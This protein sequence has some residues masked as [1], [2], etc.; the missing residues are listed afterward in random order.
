MK[1]ALLVSLLLTVHALAYDALT[2]PTELLYWNP[3]KAQ[4]G[5]T[6]FGVGGTTYL[7]DM[8]GRV[9]HTWPIG[10]N[11]HLQ[12]DGSVLDSST[13]DPSGFA[14]FRLVDWD[15]RTTWQYT[16]RR[17]TYHPHHDFIRVY[18]PKLK[19][20]TVIYIANRDYTAAECIAAG[21]NPQQ[22]PASGAQLDTLVEVDASGTIVW[23]WCFFDHLVQDLDPAKSNYVGAGKTIADHPGRL[24]INLAGHPLKGDWLHLN[25]VDYNPT[26]DQLV[27]NSVQGEFY[28]VD[29]GGTF[30]AGDPAASIAKAASTAGDFLYRFGDP[31]RYGQGT[32]PAVLADWTQSTSGTKQLGG[33]H[34]VCW[35]EPGLSGAGHFL[36]FSNAQYLSEHT[37]QSY[38]LEIDPFVGATGTNTGRY[39]NPPAAG[40]TTLKFPAVTDK[41]PRQLSRQVTWQYYSRSSLT[42]FSNIGCNAQRLANGNTLICAD[43]YGYVM[44]V[45]P[46][47]EAVWDYI[48]PVTP[49]GAVLT[50]GDNLPMVNSIFRAYRYTASH[51]A[52]TGRTLLP[53]KTIAGRTTVNNPYVGTTSYEAQQRATGLQYLDATRA[54]PGYTLFAAGGTTWLIDLQGRVVRTWPTGTNPRLLENGRLLDAASNSAGAN[55]LR[56]YDWDGNVVWEYFETRAGYR[57]QGDFVRATDPKLNAPVTFYLASRSLTAAQCLAAGCDPANG[58][59]DGAET[60]VVV[61]IDANGRVLWEWSFFDHSVQDVDATKANHVG[62]GKKISDFPGRLNLNLAGRPVRSSWPHCNALDYNPTLDQ[63]VVNS[64][65]GEF[66]VVDRGATFVANDSAASLAKAASSAGDFLYRFGD[67]ARYGA[68]SAPSVKVNWEDATN[69]NKQIG[70]SNNIQWIKPGLPG[71]G[72]FLIFNNNQYL[73][74]RTAQSYVFEINPHLNAAGADT[75]TYVAP[76]AAGYT[77]WS[78]DKDTHKSDQQLSKQVIWKYSSVG[79]LVL[80]SHY[81][82]SAQR[83]PN[84][85]TLIC[86]TT[87]GYL[88]EV[89]TTGEVVWE[90]VN[91]VTATGVVPAIGDC[92]PMTNAV[93]RALRY[94]ADFAGFTGRNL[95]PGA[96]LT[97]TGTV[98][99]ATARLVNISTRVAL[100][101]AAGTPIS[102]F[103]LSGNGQRTLLARA[104]GPTL[105]AFGVTNALA[106]PKVSLVANGAT[107]A[108][109]DNWLPTDAVVMAGTGAFALASGSKD[110]A[111]VYALTP[112]AYTLPVTAADNGTGVV[113]LEVYDTAT[114]TGSALVNASTRAYAGTG[115]SVLIV[116]FVINGTGSL[117]CLIRAVGPTLTGL[118]VDGALA[119][120]SLGLFLGPTPLTF[121][122]NWSSAANANEIGIAATAVGA[123]RLPDNSKDAAIV[124]SL[125]AGAY[126]TMVTGAANT[127]GTVLLE[128]YLLPP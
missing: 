123:F 10:N 106:D 48:M 23:E 24:N 79:N 66:Y 67:P 75:G 8:E 113:L 87:R 13:N 5:Y 92:L 49:K 12:D 73:F 118:G 28:V 40:Y 15:G 36:I 76:P 100:G 85:N 77:T 88:A 125:P 91:P 59:Y 52:L 99:T 50:L 72:H 74:Q 105:A 69:G 108:A 1:R 64:E 41:T 81:G 95:N 33:A 29:H 58:P 101:G 82:S 19:A 55:G 71:A 114:S 57:A 122:D 38:V 17:A 128:I 119:D 124:T 90:F 62:S 16:E 56:E 6:F 14:G 112:G 104:V 2:R 39:V 42:L 7:I 37:P 30:A 4:N 27:F 109:N 102:G 47:G 46:E 65:L 3:A 126:T 53:G 18:N 9:V 32:P 63:I 20:Y 111:L 22:V 116:G 35:I 84:G 68:G 11:P 115:N 98:T 44:E 117:R 97:D 96:L 26:L 107:L 25:S 78:F 103:V 31:V 43:T 89:T 61:E 94:G 83:L 45:T 93:P 21:A 60:D 70:A 51:P 34:G 86:A 80:F 54:Y 110:S 121:N 127:S 120:P